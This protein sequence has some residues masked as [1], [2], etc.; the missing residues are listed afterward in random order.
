M[1]N[2]RPPGKRRRPSLLVLGALTCCIVLLVSL[3][4][5]YKPFTMEDLLH[6]IS[7][8]RDYIEH[9][10]VSLSTAVVTWKESPETPAPAEDDSSQTPYIEFS[11]AE[12]DVSHL[13][14]E[15]T[16]P[17]DQVYLYM[18]DTQMGPMLYYH[19]GDIRWGDY[20]Y[21]GEDPMSSYGCGPTAIAMVIN[22]FSESSVDPTDMADWA[23]ENGYYALHG[24]SYHSLIPD[25]LAAYGLK[26]ESVT[27]RSRE[28]VEELLS[29]GHILVALMGR[30]ALT[31]NGHFVLFTNLLDS[32]KISI[33]DPVNY[34]NCTM[35]WD[36]DQLLLELKK[37]YDSGGPLWAVS[38]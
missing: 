26:V 24:G 11:G 3:C 27:D 10:F 34:E 4:S 32:G 6:G 35:E 16:D 5:F 1:K 25:A 15:G 22:S 37:S 8:A 19:Q 36:L 20:L 33:A 31:K 13:Q 17:S 12:G 9:Q 29:S 2:R 18:L 28:H 38:L 7:A 30:G 21:G 23:A 14:A